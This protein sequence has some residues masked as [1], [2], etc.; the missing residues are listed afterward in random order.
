MRSGFTAILGWTNVGKSTLINRLIGEK[1]AAVADVPQTT[2]NRIT[3]V[4]TLQGKGQVVFVD[5]P[6]FHRP[7]YK[8]N[9]AMVDL[10]RDAVRGVDLVLQIIDAERG[11]G[12]GDRE[13]ADLL[14][15]AGI[16]RIAALNKI[17]RIRRKSVLLP[18]LR[19]VVDDWGFPEAIPIS[20][21][22][23]EGCDTLLD[24]LLE[25][26]PESPPPFP[27][28][29]LT[30]QPERV[31]AAEFVRE[32]LLHHTREELP[33]ATAVVVEN[34]LEDEGLIRIDAVILVER[35]SQKGIVI[36]KGGSLLK[37]VGTEARLELER[38]LGSR[39][40]LQLW[41]KVRRD[42]RNDDRTLREIGLTRR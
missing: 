40:A 21:R 6:G 37:T 5:T 9:R 22:T 14:A 26:L 1:V 34:W 7:R 16:R 25:L 8:M 15:G 42:W 41:V 31:L 18:M 23:G 20:A 10:A 30:D 4:L 38:L 32:K 35:D 19:T 24:R 13:T 29:F 3:G 27:E 28:D 17:D 33:H 12:Q 36:G 2:R 11:P 39:V